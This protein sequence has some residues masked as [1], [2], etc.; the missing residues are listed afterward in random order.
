MSRARL[1]R[2]RTRWTVV[3]PFAA[4]TL[5]GGLAA[6][7]AL[8]ASVG[9]PLGDALYAT[10][11]VLVLALLF[12]RL[13]ASTAAGLGW[14]VAAGVEALQLTGVPALVVE[15]V[16]AAR[17]VL[18]S[19]FV[20]SDLAW[21]AAG[22]VVGGLVVALAHTGPS[23]T[24][25]PA[26]HTAAHRRRPTSAALVAAPL[27]LLLAGGGAVA[28]TLGSEARALRADLQAASAALAA[29]QG[30]VADDATRASLEAALAYAAAVLDSTPFLDRR[31]G[32]A[33]EAGER[34]AAQ[35]AAVTESRLTQARTDAAAARDAL[36][37]VTS[38][39]DDV[40]AATDGSGADPAVRDGLAAL[41]QQ[42]GVTAA[43]AADD[44]LA[45]ATD[46]LAVEQVTAAL[47]AAGD[48]VA[49]ATVALMTA[50]DAAVCPFPD[51]VWFPES[52]RLADDELAAVPWEPRYRIRADLLPSLVALDEAFRA[53]FDEHLDLNSAYRSYAEQLA[54][55]NPANPNPL[56][57]VPGCSNH[58]LGTAIDLNGISAP[59]SAKY[60]WLAANAERYGWTHPDWAEPDGR[61]PEPW[62]WQSVE[63]PT[64]Y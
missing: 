16:P 26:R 28:L 42:A 3:A 15:R 61:L 18:G 21:Y 2:R 24:A 20:A 60:A 36:A 41:L 46:P 50:Q 53:E 51:Q 7:T 5:A 35:V 10:L 54:V 39:A 9:G 37:P 63:T 27:A 12:R 58:G 55:Y 52:G 22:A 38:R 13:H 33:P 57:A 17:W 6:R 4:A 47:T 48:D 30:K 44:R 62:H 45:V 23:R 34:V 11:A 31:P 64:T 40:L 14:A 32:D 25:P 49:Q 8:P 29:S 56:A 19:T 43:G 1:P 59:G